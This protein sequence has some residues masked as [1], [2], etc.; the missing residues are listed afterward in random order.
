MEKYF[1]MVR[2]PFKSN[3][4]YLS[5]SLFRLSP[6]WLVAVS[7]GMIFLVGCGGA[8]KKLHIQDTGEYQVQFYHD[9]SVIELWTDFDV[10]FE[11]PLTM[12]YRISFYQEGELVTEVSCDP[13]A[14]DEK[15]MQRYVEN[16]G[17]VK[18]S[19]LGQMQCDVDLP[20]GET[21]VAVQFDAHANRFKIF[22]ADLIIK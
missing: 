11:E 15:R 19:Y 9:G 22:R 5:F 8:D 2:R 1:L 21:L 7:L 12:L 16:N 3:T 10:E 6:V 13:F 20:E 18:V 17:L 14:A 4:S